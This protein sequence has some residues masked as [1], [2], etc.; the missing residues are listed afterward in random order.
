VC[1]WQV[2]LPIATEGGVVLAKHQPWNPPEISCEAIYE[3][4]WNLWTTRQFPYNALEEGDL[5]LTVSGGG[6]RSGRVINQ[7]EV[8]DLLK[9]SYGSMDEA[10]AAFESFYPAEFLDAYG[11]NLTSFKEQ[12]YNA[13]A[14]SAGHI[15]AWWGEPRLIID[16]PRPD[17]LRFRPNGWAE[18][19]AEVAAQLIAGSREV[20]PDDAT[21]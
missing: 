21:D 1:I 17:S 11:L 14:P 5:I 3:F 6:P 16:K 13:Q 15:L 12:E 19:D 2:D 4:E 18:V 7:V 10:W 8:Q 20:P 9:A